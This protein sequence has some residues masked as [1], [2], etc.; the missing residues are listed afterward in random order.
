MSSLRT[1]KLLTAQH[2]IVISAPMERV[3]AALTQPEQI[4]RWWG[5]DSVYW[6]TKV[7]QELRTGGAANYFGTFTS[8]DAVSGSAAGRTFASTGLTLAADPPRLL[9]YTRRYSDGIPC[10][11]ETVIRYEL[12]PFDGGTRL[13]VVNRGFETEEMRDLH[14]QGWERA[15]AWLDRYLTTEAAD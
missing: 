7:K 14:T 2:T 1:D 5:D 12:E 3:F 4:T 15:F 9:E 8:G 11:E 6:M 13:T 10:A